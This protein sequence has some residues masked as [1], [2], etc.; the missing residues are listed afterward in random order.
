MKSKGLFQDE[1]LL[2]VWNLRLRMKV[3]GFRDER[4]LTT[5]NFQHSA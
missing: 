4:S 3:L 5:N 1:S 2:N